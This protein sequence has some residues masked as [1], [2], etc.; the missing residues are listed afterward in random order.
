MHLF[1]DRA[2]VKSNLGNSSAMYDIRRVDRGFDRCVVLLG[3]C[4]GEAIA[5]V[6]TLFMGL[7]ALTR[8]TTKTP[9]SPASTVI[10]LLAVPATINLAVCAL[11]AYG[12]PA[13]FGRFLALPAVLLEITCFIGTAQLL[14]SP[15]RQ[16]AMAVLLTI[17][18]WGG[19]R[20]WMSYV[21]DDSG[22]TTRRA[23]AEILQDQQSGGLI[24][25]GV[26]AEPA[27]YCMP[28][29]DLQGLQLKLI[30]QTP[31]RFILS[32]SAPAALWP[33]EWAMPIPPQCTGQL[34]EGPT[35]SFMTPI[36]WA[37][38]PFLFLSLSGKEE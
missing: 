36:S 14:R 33:V 20:Y 3:E 6:G 35:G 9:D 16:C 10:W 5:I 8:F 18:L 27:P 26:S 11:L 15:V 22:D 2:A 38:K 7:W 1:G 32:P 28:P 21:A 29:F 31:R 34:I 4:D 24:L 12:K 17:A 13:E 30:R 25:L 23:A 19:G 37:S